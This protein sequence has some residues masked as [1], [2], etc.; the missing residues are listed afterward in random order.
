MRKRKGFCWES[1]RGN[2]CCVLGIEVRKRAQKQTLAVSVLCAFVF[3]LSRYVSWAFVAHVVSRT[4]ERTI[5]RKQ[6]S[7]RA[8]NERTNERCVVP[9]NLCALSAAHP[10]QSPI[11]EAPLP[12]TRHT[13]NVK[14][15]KPAAILIH[16]VRCSKLT[17]NPNDQFLVLD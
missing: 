2:I 14:S 16:L 9:H 12:L 13:N 5:E 10:F 4:S 8:K 17:S 11:C 6:A 3:L 15:L 1:K 7:E